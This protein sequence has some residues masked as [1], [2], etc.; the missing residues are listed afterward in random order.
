MDEVVK[1][2]LKELKTKKI[3]QDKIEKENMSQEIPGG[4]SY[5]A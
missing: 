4:T 2:V 5:A 3:E 1:A